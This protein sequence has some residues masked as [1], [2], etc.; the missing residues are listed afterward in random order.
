MRSI[1]WTPGIGDPGFAGWLT[2]GAYF[3]TAMLCLGPLVR[4][5]PGTVPGAERSLW[6]FLALFFLALGLNKQLDLQS[7]FTELLR[8]QALADGWYQRRRA[9]QT[10]F[11]AVLSVIGVGAVAVAAYR[12]R[13]SHPA[14]KLA[15][16]GLLFIVTFIGL[17]AAS[18]H[19]A[20]RFL[21][22]SP[23]GLRMNWLL[24][25]GGIASVAGS[26]LWRLRRRSGQ[27]LP[28]VENG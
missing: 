7:L 3:A 10:G 9:Y 2:V 26:A 16:V 4:V 23:G 21:G 15:V 27:P 5:R 22:F 11:L 25:L 20:D 28:K 19:H 13:S 8:D 6:L 1:D 17:R 18:F 24:E 14:V 12:F